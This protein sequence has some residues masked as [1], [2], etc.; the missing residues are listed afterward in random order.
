MSI[1]LQKEIAQEIKTEDSVIVKQLGIKALIP[2]A[3]HVSVAGSDGFW[4]ITIAFLCDTML[5]KD[6]P[7]LRVRLHGNNPVQEII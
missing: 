1:I 7:C 4:M 2:L 5:G 3:H 6:A